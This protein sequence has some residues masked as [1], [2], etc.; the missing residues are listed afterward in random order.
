MSTKPRD[1]QAAGPISDAVAHSISAVVAA[2]G[3]KPVDFAVEEI[4]RAGDREVDREAWLERAFSLIAGKA[5]ARRLVSAAP[6]RD[7]LDRLRHAATMAFGGAAKVEERNAALVVYALVVAAGLVHHGLLLSSQ[8][9]TEIDVMLAEL[10][11]ILGEPFASFLE[12]AVARG[13]RA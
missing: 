3:I 12:S 13:V 1:T 10:A 11:G 5:G 6:T 8:P 7:E 2:G 9:R 4:R